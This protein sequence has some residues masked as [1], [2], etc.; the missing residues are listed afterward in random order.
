VDT[1]P[2]ARSTRR[3]RI[4]GAGLILA[5]FGAAV[6]L[7][8]PAALTRVDGAVYDTLLRRVASEPPL[9]QIVIVDI[10]ERS[11]AAVGQWPWRRDV[12]ARLIARLRDM[13][14]RTIALAVIFAE[15]D[16][17]QSTPGTAGAE[18]RS[19]ENAAGA[20]T[21][22]DARLAETLRNA[23]GVLGYA[24]T[25]ERA[26]GSQHCVLHPLRLTIVQPAGEAGDVPL[27]QAED[28][29][30]SLPVFA[31]AAGASGFLNAAPDAD[32]ILRR[33]PLVLAF[34]DRAYPAL[35]LAAVTAAQA[36]E[37]RV[38]NANT[39]SL[40]VG[41]RVV[42]LDGR[43]NL[44]IRYRGPKR[45][46]PYVAAADV[47][48][49]RL[50]ADT[51]RDRIVFVGA[52][53]LG[54]QELVATPHDL[55]FPGVEVQA[56]VADN[57]LR[58]DFIRRL[59]HG[60]LLQL[61][62]VVGFSLGMALLMG[63]AG[64]RWG[65]GAGLLALLGLWGAVLW[66]LAGAGVYLSPLLAS[67]AVVVAVAVLS[68]VALA[69]D[70]RVAL[71]GLQH[72]RRDAE[73]AAR[74][75]NEF[76]MNVSH[77]L[78]TPLS[79]IYGYAQ[80]LGKGGL[81][82]EQRIRALASLE[83]N[84]RAQTQLID[85][86]LVASQSATGR[87]RLDVKGVDLGELVRAALETVRPAIEAKRIRLHAA[88]ADDVGVIPGD[89]DR[90]QQVVWNLLSNAIKFT[91]DRGTVHVQLERVKTSAL[92]TVS[93]TGRG[94]TAEFLPHVFEQFRQQDSGATRE[95]GGLGLGL[96]LS[97]HVVEL[98]GGSI[99]AESAGPGRGA[100]FRVRL[101]LNTASA[102]AAQADDAA[103]GADRLAQRRVL[104]VD[105]NPQTRAAVASALLDAGA[106]V[107]TAASA[108]DALAILREGGQDA[109]AV[110]LDMANDD[111]YR[112]VD[113]ATT[114]AAA[115]DRRLRIVAFG[116]SSSGGR[117]MELIRLGA[118]RHLPKPVQP[119][120]LVAAIR[121][122]C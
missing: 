4:L 31:Q 8:P 81:R 47:L 97:R 85:D 41:D 18:A 32:G 73:S 50:P 35:P 94:I 64:V 100:T 54:I 114:I 89:R 14:A 59:E 95:H 20:Q 23:G 11:L 71:A 84:A 67:G 49:G 116:G 88:V 66:L 82:D 48:D 34:D 33:V 26:A 30:C 2:H 115:R 112:L 104:V 29:L 93:D 45:T 76:L 15:P 21:A 3:G 51:F 83:R 17:D 99:E 87:L 27:F 105:D 111:G 110:S 53:A 96:A 101:P 12:I 13:E 22:S 65:F 79:V 77:E 75:R 39:L 90:L 57:L 42:P 44:L 7:F 38:V 61:M 107:V 58:G 86:L 10:D 70:V 102:A 74:A 1:S 69:D 118:G 24:F 40:T 113:E 36:G 16:R 56:T 68:F 63:R 117:I 43:G 9:G 98:H 103:I 5:I 72:A 122:L 62:M 119:G 55:L 46:F 108:Q 80:M 28:A 91:P 37:L 6:V 120:Q 25:F 19:R 109:L 106:G 60:R 92:I 121:E 52:T 78:R